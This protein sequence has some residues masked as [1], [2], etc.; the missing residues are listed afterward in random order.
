MLDLKTSVPY[1]VC[2]SLDMLDVNGRKVRG[3]EY[4]W[5][6]MSIEDPQHSDFVKLRSMLVANM[7]DMREVTNDLHYENYR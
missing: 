4:P 6:V 2:S 5:G 7:E 1:A 3:R